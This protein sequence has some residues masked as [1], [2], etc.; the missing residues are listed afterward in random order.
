MSFLKWL[1]G[2]KDQDDSGSPDG[3]YVP[4]PIGYEHIAASNFIRDSSP[5]SEWRGDHDWQ[6][7]FPPYHAEPYTPIRQT[8]QSLE[9]MAAKLMEKKFVMPVIVY[10][11]YCGAANTITNPT[12]VACGAAPGR[13]GWKKA[14]E[15]QSSYFSPDLGGLHG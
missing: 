12:C 13:E 14:E 7:V 4:T 6:R 9:E 15:K 5:D 10:C 2:K 1:F 8:E 11:T 3:V